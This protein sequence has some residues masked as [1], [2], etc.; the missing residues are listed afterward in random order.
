MDESKQS[1]KKSK[2]S[3]KQTNNAKKKR[4][5][6]DPDAPKRPLGPYFFYFKANNTKI[7][8]EHPEF[9]QKSV[10][11]KIA[12]DWKYLTEEEKLPFVEK[13]REDKLR[14]IREKE[15]Y[16]ENRHK[17]EEEEE[18]NNKGCKQ[19][20][21][22]KSEGKAIHDNNGYASK[23]YGFEI[24]PFE[25]RE[26]RLADIIG[27]D[28]VSYPSDSELLAPYSP[29]ASVDGSKASF[30]ER[31]NEVANTLENN[32]NNMPKQINEGD[33]KEEFGSKKN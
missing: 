26:V 27:A 6:K 14:Y 21:G 7:K 25:E 11:A 8:N 24:N 10:V 5:S 29:P 20:R 3:Q 32:Y 17:K 1:K 23:H 22:K 30:V 18:K 15:V 13:S 28:Q 12:A 33:L 4:K 9:N 19:K 31:M 2:R 16:E